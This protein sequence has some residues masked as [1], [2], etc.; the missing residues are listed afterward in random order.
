MTTNKYHICV[1]DLGKTNK[2]IAVFDN[3]LNLLHK[4]SVNF[5]MAKYKGIEIDQMD[6][7][8]SW[9]MG[10]IKALNKKYNIKIIGTTTYGATITYI[11]DK[12]KKLVFPVISYTHEPGEKFQKEF[13]NVFGSPEK[14]FKTTACPNF[15]MFLNPGKQIYWFK[16]HYPALFSQVTDILC[17][18]EYITYVFTG[19]KNAELTYIGTHAYMYDYI[20]NKFSSVIEKMKIR[21]LFPKKLSKV[22]DVSGTI[23]PEISHKTGLPLS[24]KMT[25]GIHDSNASLLPYLLYGYKKFLLASTGT[26]CCFMYPNAKLSLSNDDLRKNV[27]YYTDAFNKPVRAAIFRGGVEHDHYNK[28]LQKKFGG[29][30]YKTGFNK[31]LVEEILTNCNCFV[32]PTLTPGAGQFPNSKPRIIN[33]KFF[34]RNVETGYTVLCLSL[35][36]QSYFAAKLL[37][38][39]EKIPVFVEGG[40]TNNETYLK[41]FAGMFKNLQFYTSEIKEATSFGTAICAKSG[42]ENIPMN[43]I[44]KKLIKIKLNRIQNSGINPQLL[45]K[46]ILKFEQLTK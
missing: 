36:V 14:L 22:S 39:D 46:Y 17:L 40:F 27:L 1:I 21:H 37:V 18:P 32:M 30:P 26:W 43:R 31:K 10:K 6:K 44:S 15:G 8:V 28:L 4:E 41:V 16:K 5:N 38:K 35:A 7:I 9:L 34:Y 2:K 25:V 33:E 29:K 12:T 19:K 3:T 13:Y 42:Y 20:N 24:T 23:L 11:N 45:G